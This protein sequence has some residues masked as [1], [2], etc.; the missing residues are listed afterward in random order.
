MSSSSADCVI[1]GD[2]ERCPSDLSI[3]RSS[4]RYYIDSAIS[5]PVDLVSQ[6][7]FATASQYVG[8]CN[9]LVDVYGPGLTPPPQTLGQQPLRGSDAETGANAP[10]QLD[11]CQCRVCPPNRVFEYAMSCDSEILGPCK[12]FNCDGMCNMELD[13]LT[14]SP[15]SSTVPSFS[16]TATPSLR[17]TGQP[18]DNTVFAPPTSP[19]P[20][21]SSQQASESNT[22]PTF[23]GAVVLPPYSLGTT[24]TSVLALLVFWL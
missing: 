24:I 21:S 2:F 22:L 13:L 11:N 16:P 4:S 6:Y 3:M 15:S 12:S 18:S 19:Q 5:C 1:D 10:L 7:G 23:S 20:T 17:P 8:A 14:F 9:C